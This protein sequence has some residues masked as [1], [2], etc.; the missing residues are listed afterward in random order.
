MLQDPEVRVTDGITES[1]N[2]AWQRIR[3]PVVMP[4]LYVAF[5]ICVAM[6][7][8]LFVERIYM[9]AVILSVKF[10][11]KKRY[12][13]YKLEALKEDL[14]QNKSYPMVLIQ[15]PMFNEREV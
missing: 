8:M 2:D 7:I 13:K 1:L 14:E 4:I 6:S 11:G 9:T 12:T 10:L 15:I 3:A 5:Y